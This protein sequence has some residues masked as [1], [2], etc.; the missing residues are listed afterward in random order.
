[1]QELNKWIAF[2]LMLSLCLEPLNE[3]DFNLAGTTQ[4]QLISSFEFYADVFL[5]ERCKMHVRYC[6]K[7]T[8]TASHVLCRE[9]YYTVSLFRRVHYYIGGSL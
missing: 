6:R 2:T 7:Y 5:F 1:M 4:I 9:V 8:G 3:G